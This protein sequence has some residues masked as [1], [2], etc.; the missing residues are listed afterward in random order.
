MIPA[1]SIEY[2]W[3]PCQILTVYDLVY[4]WAVCPVGLIVCYYVGS[5][6]F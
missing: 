4:F 1:P 3:F 6:L 2:S 5:T